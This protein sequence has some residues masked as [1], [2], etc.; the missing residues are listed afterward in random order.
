[1]AYFRTML[2]DTKYKTLIDN[3]LGKV[4]PERN[5]FIFDEAVTFSDGLHVN[6]ACLTDSKGNPYCRGELCE[7]GEP[8]EESR[9]LAYAH[10]DAFEGEWIFHLDPHEEQYHV[11]VSVKE[12]K[13]YYA[14]VAIDVECPANPN[15]NFDPELD[16][17]LSSDVDY[18]FVYNDKESGINIINTELQE[19]TTTR[20]S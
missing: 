8:G 5:H 19:W 18:Q 11:W 10:K 15:P 7:S 13:R 12:T 4:H 16:N 20:P 1:M 14:L 3:T 6:I 2:I 17:V 9:V